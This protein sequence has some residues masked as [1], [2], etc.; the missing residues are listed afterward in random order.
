MPEA[1]SAMES[2]EE[3]AQ[4]LVLIT[5]PSGAGRSTA[6]N[7]LEDLGY[8]AI[9]NLPLSLIPRL[10]DGPA[11][12]MP[13]ALGL[14]VRNRDF[15]VA[16]LIELIDRLTRLPEYAP[17]VL[18]L[19]CTTEQLLRRFNE[20][21][22][23]HPLRAEGSPLDAIIAERD[24]LAPIRA[25]ADVLVDTS[26]LS[27]HDLK[28]ELARW[29]D[30]E[31]GRRLTVSVQSFSYKR[32]VPRGVDMMFDCRFLTNPHWRPDLRPLDG[33][34]SPVQHYVMA[35]SRFDEFFRRVQDLVLF[36]LPAH[37][38]EGKAH[39][40]IGFGCTGGR[41]RSVTMAEKMADALAKAGWQ[42]SI[43]HRELERRE[44]APAPGD[45]GHM[46]ASRTALAQG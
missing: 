35:D 27:P 6:I 30:T 37:L 33:R 43:R 18:F 16:N 46:R 10:L 3:R 28:A 32:G 9:D 2:Q 5:G 22:R 45:D 14:D 41:H 31:S 13:L 40:A 42:V 39:L 15:S 25:R 12:P 34:D 8:E 29:F 7:V 38:D 4:R 44:K 1:A 24:M 20:T 36:T 19:D 26:D 17:E 23:R 11:R 21:R